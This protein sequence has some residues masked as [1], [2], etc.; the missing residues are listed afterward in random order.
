MVACLQPCNELIR[1]VLS[2][3]ETIQEKHHAVVVP[4]S[5]AFGLYVLLQLQEAAQPTHLLDN[6]LCRVTSLNAQNLPLHHSD[7]V[8]QSFT[9]CL[10]LIISM[11]MMHKLQYTTW[12]RQPIPRLG[13]VLKKGEVVCQNQHNIINLRCSQMCVILSSMMSESLI[14]M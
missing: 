8:E 3:L 12:K 2:P 14:Q 10:L 11:R 13:L 7:Y 9:W 1:P 4:I 6:C 5:L